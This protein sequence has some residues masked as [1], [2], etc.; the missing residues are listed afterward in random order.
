MALVENS[1]FFISICVYTER[2]AA[3]S[4]CLILDIVVVIYKNE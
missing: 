2:A 3:I 1:D 4:K